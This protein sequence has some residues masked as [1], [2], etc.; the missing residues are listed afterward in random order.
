MILIFKGT[1]LAGSHACISLESGES[2]T[3]NLVHDRMYVTMF[4]P[5]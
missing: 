4:L 3:V 1:L 5:H 2:C